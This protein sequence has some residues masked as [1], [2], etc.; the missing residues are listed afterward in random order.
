MAPADHPLETKAPCYT[1]RGKRKCIQVFNMLLY[2]A[3][4]PA[5]QN[6]AKKKVICTFHLGCAAEVHALASKRL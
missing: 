3:I 1:R 2:F 4:I 6:T 5:E